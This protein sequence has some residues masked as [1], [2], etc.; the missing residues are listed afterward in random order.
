MSRDYTGDKLD[1]FW[2]RNNG[3]TIVLDGVKHVLGVDVYEAIYPTERMVMTVHA[4]VKN[5]QS[6]YYR[7][8]KQRLGDDWSVDVLESDPNVVLQI[9]EQIPYEEMV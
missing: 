5:K 1:E 8:E 2:V 7:D 6:K 9:M 4:E 3:R